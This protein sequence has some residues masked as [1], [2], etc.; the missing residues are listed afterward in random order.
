MIKSKMSLW[1]ISSAT[2]LGMISGCTKPNEIKN[3]D[4]GQQI[5]NTIGCQNFRS[6]IFDAFYEY[7][8]KNKSGPQLNVV[9]K[10]SKE[11]LKQRLSELSIPDIDKEKFQTLTSEIIS[12]LG[13][14][15]SL[16]TESDLEKIRWL[17]ELESGSVSSSFLKEQ[18][19]ELESKTQELKQLVQKYDVVCAAPSVQRDPAAELPPSLI[20]KNGISAIVKGARFTFANAYQNCDVLTYP[21]M[22]T[23]VEPLQG[24]ERDKPVDQVGWGRKYTNLPLLRSTHYY[25]HGFVQRPLCLSADLKPLVY[26]YGGVP[27]IAGKNLLNYFSNAGI[28]GPALGVDCSAFVSTA[29]AQAGLRYS[30]GLDNKPI[31]T[32]RSSGDFLNPETH[33]LTCFSRIPVTQNESLKVGDIMAINGHVVIIDR[34]GS[35][36]F[37]IANISN[38][39]LCSSL[40]Y[41]NFDF[42][43][44]QSSASKNSIGINRYVIREYLA[45]SS[46]AMRSGFEKYAIAACQSRFDGKVRTI[47]D[48]STAIIRHKGTASCMAGSHVRLVGQECIESCSYSRA[49]E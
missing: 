1:A 42:T 5:S 37:G 21:D 38:I 12:I 41:K 7:I 48:A 3:Q 30:P 13:K 2:F 23:S 6:Q 47:K 16:D 9:Q 18:G 43:I 15:E 49:G 32:R 22:T 46:G 33:G 44:L 25:I 20:D 34:A 45:E 29:I 24:V 28:G 11:S 19:S 31:Y 26:D 10:Y 39:N 8:D 4:L 27:S 35:D 36:P 14:T 17:I 40:T